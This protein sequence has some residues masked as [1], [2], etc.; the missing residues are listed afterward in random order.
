MTYGFS[1]FARDCERSF[2]YGYDQVANFTPADLDRVMEAFTA[3]RRVDQ[4]KSRAHADLARHLI[5]ERF[6]AEVDAD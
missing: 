3:Q 2:G 5:R 4:E 1:E 6:G